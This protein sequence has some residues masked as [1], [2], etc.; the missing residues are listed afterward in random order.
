MA[1]LPCFPCTRSGPVG[2][3]LAMHLPAPPRPT[4]P[5]SRPD[6]SLGQHVATWGSSSSPRKA[7]R[8]QFRQ[9]LSVKGQMVNILGF[10]KLWGLQSVETLCRQKVSRCVLLRSET[11]L[12]QKEAVGCVWPVS[13]SLRTP[14]L[15]KPFPAAT[16]QCGSPW[17]W[18][19]RAPDSHSCYLTLSPERSSLQIL[20]DICHQSES[21]WLYL[22]G[23][24][25]CSYCFV[26]LVLF[27][28]SLFCHGPVP[29][30]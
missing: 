1:D 8:A 5:T 14:A 18:G 16:G 11:L 21:C 9:S 19:T 26:P 25:V 4:H 13:H 28:S 17:G 12:S 6:P 7:Q 23:F 10:P 2:D 15:E 30:F 29:L 3:V 27:R 20:V 24:R 22:R